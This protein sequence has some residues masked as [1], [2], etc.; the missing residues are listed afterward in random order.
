LFS[1][2]ITGTVTY[3][4]TPSCEEKALGSYDRTYLY[5]GVN[6]PWDTNPF[7]F[8][9]YH[10]ASDEDG[11]FGFTNDLIFNLDFSSAAW[12]CYKGGEPCGPF[13][14]EDP[15]FVPVVYLDMSGNNNGSKIERVEVGDEDGYTVT[16][17]PGTWVGN[18]TGNGVDVE[19]ECFAANVDV[20]WNPFVWYLFPLSPPQPHIPEA[21]Y[22]KRNA[23]TPLSYTISFS[24]STASLSLVT[25]IPNSVLT[26][27]FTGTR[28]DTFTSLQKFPIQLNTSSFNPEIP[29]FN[30]LNG[31][32]ILFAKDSLGGWT[33]AASP[34]LTNAITSSTST[35]TSALSTT[36]TTTGSGATTTT[37]TTATR[38]VATGGRK[39]SDGVTEICVFVLGVVGVVMAG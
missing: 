11:I 39:A 28:N 26:L 22:L 14:T 38:N 9:L 32:E 5:V 35:S 29:H 4:S 37:T 10:L 21:N 12:E 25:T 23:S 1:G 36:P 15:Y 3:P 30:Y 6:P 17:G 16:G 19:A 2:N 33:A 24:N 27:S 8:E 34:I 7:F 13:F 20:N 31:S 18:D